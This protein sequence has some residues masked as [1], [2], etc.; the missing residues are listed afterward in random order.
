M[1]W[2]MKS[3]P[4]RCGIGPGLAEAG[5][6]A[7]DQARVD[8]GAGWRGRGRI[9]RARRP[10]SSRSRHRRRRPARGPAAWPSGVAMS[11]ATA[12][13]CRGWSSGNRRRRGSLPS[14]SCRN[15]GPQWRVSSPAPGR[16]TLITSAPRSASSCPH[17]GPARIRASSTTLMP[18][19]GFMR[20]RDLVD[21]R[22]GF[23]SPAI[24]RISIA[25]SQHA[26]D[27]LHRPARADIVLAD[28]E[29]GG[30]DIAVDV[31]EHQRA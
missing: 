4:A 10:C 25:G 18:A 24:S 27:L 22:G 14:A 2:M 21:R 3:Y 23:I 29:H 5:D 7:G 19:S 1:P 15:G 11:I 9:W 26:A 31:I 8:R 20:P 30:A 13:S 28:R 6:R 12:R 16:S 17:H